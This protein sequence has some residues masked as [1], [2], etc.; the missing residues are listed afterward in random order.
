M[1]SVIN[2]GKSTG[3]VKGKYWILDSVDGTF[4]FV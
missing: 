2:K 1:V 3:G 4:G